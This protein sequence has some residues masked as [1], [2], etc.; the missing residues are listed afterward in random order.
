M[1]PVFGA[2][3]GRRRTRWFFTRYVSGRGAAAGA[4]H[5][6]PAVRHP[7]RRR[8]LSQLA[9]A[10]RGATPSARRSWRRQQRSSPVPARARQLLDG[11]ARR[12]DDSSPR[13]SRFVGKP[14]DAHQMLLDIVGLHPA[15]VEFHQR[16][17]ESLEHLFNRAK[18][19]RL[20]AQL[21][22]EQ[23][24]ASRL[25]AA[26]HRRCCGGSGYTGEATPD[27]LDEVL[28]RARR[29]GSTGRSSTTGR[30]PRPT[31]IRAYTDDGRN[32]LAWLADAART[33]LE[34]LRREHGFTD[35]RPPDALLYLM[36][37]HALLLGYW[38][39][40]LRLHLDGR[41]CSTPPRWRRRGASRAFMHVAAGDARAESRYAPLLHA[42]TRASPAT[43]TLT[44]R[45][46]HPRIIGRL[47]AT[48]D[49]AEQLAALD[50]AR[51]A[52]PPRASS[53][54]S[55]STSTPRSYRLDAW[56]LGL[57]Q[58]PARGAALPCRA[59]ERPR[60]A[61]A[62]TSAPTAGSRTCGRR[63][64]PLHAGHARRTSCAAELPAR[65]RTA[66]L[67]RDRA[68]GGYVH[69]PSLNHAAT[70]AVLRNG[71]LANATPRQPEPLAVNL[72]SRARARSR[73]VIEGIRNGSRS[74]RCSAT[75]FERGL[76]DGHGPLEV[77]RFI[78]PLRKAFPLR[79]R[80]A[81]VD[82]ATARRRPIEA[83]EARNVRRRAGARRARRARPASAATRSGYG[84]ARPPTGGRARRHRRR[85]RRACSTPTTRSPTWR[86]PR[87]CTRRCSATTT[88]SPPRSTRTRRAGFPPEPE[89]VRTPRSGIAPHPPRRAASR[90][91]ASIPPPRRS[92]ASR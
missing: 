16:Y 23:S 28:L 70:A 73:S 42:A 86:S 91:R 92:P 46:A 25:D 37:R 32:Y 18:P 72:S 15:S 85:G 50:A 48:A 43:P 35:D 29:A 24:A 59:S 56:L 9:L 66:P 49:L 21:L 80:P 64:A 17:A 45:R 89:V 3:A 10:R 58:L 39:T 90:R 2:R 11:D 19:Q 27:V 20:G 68:N 81:D 51:A 22:A 75:S 52:C 62:S 4:P 7:A 40:S 71:Y 61:R 76:H 77:D 79:R 41:A 87:A 31:P 33:S 12:L 30:C 13:R 84:A 78:Y 60:R 54:A 5:R 69:A 14:G 1:Q 47:R 53:A 34:T 63:T 44:R 88:A 65:R 8:A 57:V 55:P 6:R 67:V 74:A 82:A 83:I 38:D 36:L 26:A